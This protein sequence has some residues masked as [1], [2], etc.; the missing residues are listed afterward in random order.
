[1]LAYGQGDVDEAEAQ[2]AEALALAR[3]RNELALEALA[4]TVRGLVAWRHGDAQ[5]AIRLHREALAL[6][7]RVGNP[8]LLGDLL[9][10]L[11]MAESVSDPAA[12]IESLSE[13]LEHLRI[14]GGLHHLVLTMGAL[15]DA[16][17]RLGRDAEARTRLLESL[18]LS[19]AEPDPI[20][21]TWVLTFALAFLAEHGKAAD[22]VALLEELDAYASS[23][24][25]LRTPLETSAYTRAAVA[26]SQ[27]VGSRATPAPSAGDARSLEQAL[28]ETQRLMQE[29]A[30]A[31]TAPRYPAGLTAREVEVLRLV[32]AGLTNPQV[33]ER[34]YLSPRTVD[35]H[36]QRIYAKLDVSS[37]GAAIRFAVDNGLT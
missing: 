34:L 7:R 21:A 15:A 13:G 12:A 36:L 14:A 28:T 8:F 26:R 35:A 1:V 32:S 22:V 6:A 10:H 37:R 18:E 29:V 23:V 9:Y 24:G 33:A 5:T 17:G 19:R 25:Y 2:A 20:A 16:E 27:P 3:S 4:T 30:V 11:G 31:A